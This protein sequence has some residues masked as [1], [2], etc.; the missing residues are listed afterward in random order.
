MVYLNDVVVYSDTWQEHVHRIRQLFDRLRDAHLTVNLAKCEFAK[1]T[2]TLLG[3]VVGQGQVWPVQ[4]KVTAI[5]Q[6]PV[7]TT[8]KELMRF[9]G[10]VGYYRSFCTKFSTVIAP[11]T[12]LLKARVKFV[13][14]ASCQQAFEN[15]KAVLC[16]PPVLVAPC[17]DLPF[18][19]QVGRE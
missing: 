6:Y 17:L 14:S 3:K 9:L 16:F 5:E 12:D 18:E 7:P 11:L 8:K 4:A 15:V 2:V 1:A 19:L 10:L 13:W